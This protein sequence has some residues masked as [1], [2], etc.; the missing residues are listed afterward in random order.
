MRRYIKISQD[1][2]AQ[3]YKEYG[4]TKMGLWKILNYISNSSRAKEIRQFAINNGGLLMEEDFIPNCKTEH[5]PT[6][7]IQSFPGGISVVISKVQNCGEI[8]R[9]GETVEKLEDLRLSQWGTILYRAQQ[10]SIESYN[11]N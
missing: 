7:I 4:L 8:R 9:E 10:M 1:L 11:A 3:L 2:R 6:E 5:T